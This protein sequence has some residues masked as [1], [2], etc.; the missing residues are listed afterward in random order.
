MSIR[1]P[2]GLINQ[3]APVPSG[4][5]AT[6]TA[7]GVWT[8]EQQAYWKQQGLWPIP[9][10]FPPN[11]E[12]VFSTY[13]YTGTGAALT[14]NNGIDLSGKGGLVW[15]KSRSDAF[16]NFLFDTSRGA[17][18]A[19]FSNDT[20]AAGSTPQALTAFNSNGFSLGTQANTNQSAS[21]F[22]SWT[23]RE[24]A[25]FFDVVTYTGTGVTRAI[26]H[27]LG[28]TP[29]MIIVKS[30]SNNA[31]WIVYHRSLGGTKYIIL[32]S[33]GAEVTS[34]FAWANT[35]PTSSV[36]TVSGSASSV[37]NINGQTYVAYL[38]AH[39]AGGFGLSGNDN[40]ISCGSF[41]TDGSGA[42]SVN[43]GYEPQYI[44]A[45][46]S[47]SVQNWIVLDVMRGW[48]MTNQRPLNPNLANAES[49]SSAPY[50]PPNATGFSSVDNWFGVNTTV[51]YM[52]IR[53]PMAVPTV[54]TSVFMPIIN[55]GVNG[56]QTNTTN[57]PVDLSIDEG[58]VTNFG[59]IFFDRLRGQGPY[60]ISASDGNEGNQSPNYFIG[61]DSNT[62]VFNKNYG[63][64]PTYTY[65][66]WLLR[67]APG[68]MDVVCY[69]GSSGSALSHNLGVAPELIFIKR[70]NGVAASG[71]VY[72]SALGLSQ[73]VLLFSDVGSN[74]AGSLSWMTSI[75]STV[76]QP[77]NNAQ[78]NGASTNTYVAYLFATCAGV[79]K[80]GSYTGTGATQ[81]IN[82]G[83][84]A[85][86]RFVLIKRTDST[87]D[88]YVW[89]SARGIVAGNDPYLLLN[90]SAAEVTNT[91]FVD[92]AAT[93]FEISSTAPAAINANGGS[94][95][96][97]A[98]A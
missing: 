56:G 65:V 45:K 34:S 91:D 46:T 35:D 75:S 79:S 88:W 42:F 77:T 55:T 50:F 47:S 3:T 12:D 33:T 37:T 53:R 70:R 78:W 83:F 59:A 24:Q 22:C 29:G 92:T 15:L 7:S 27:N 62:G 71:L 26:S 90:S 23:F 98:I 43:L 28:S 40:V 67:R 69:S 94:F 25:K 44:L 31:N 89:D 39:N 10:N 73:Y 16:W 84:T 95:I 4:I 1:W 87:G 74:A 85:G 38:F 36:F 66:N 96:F 6:S 2:G 48:D 13:L 63:N 30:T 49:N 68:F 97:L 81:T 58:R 86:S 61:F 52:A 11:I 60:L 51:I 19:L 54:G 82:C 41:T 21:T 18:S 9:G 76:F 72:S 93:G 64:L 57:F 8:L 5:L 14:I 20:G 32:N 80:V 17:G